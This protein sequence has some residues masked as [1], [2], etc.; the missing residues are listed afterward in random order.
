MRNKLHYSKPGR[1]SPQKVF[2]HGWPTPHLPLKQMAPPV[3]H[4]SPHKGCTQ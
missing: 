4:S 1:E 2:P 3:Q